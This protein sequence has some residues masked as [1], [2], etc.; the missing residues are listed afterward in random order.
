MKP[1]YKDQIWL[2][3]QYIEKKRSPND[4]ANEIGVATNTIIYWLKKFHIP[5]R[6]Y[7]EANHLKAANHVQ[8]SPHAIEFIEGELLGDG[9]LYSRSQWS[10]AYSHGSKYKE[11]ID[12]LAERLSGF[13]IKQAGS[14]VTQHPL[15]R[16]T[17]YNY[18]S[19]SYEELKPMRDRW[20]PKGKKIVP[21][22]LILTPLMVRQW[23]IGDGCLDTKRGKRSSIRL[24]TCSFSV[25]DVLYLAHSLRE[26]GFNARRRSSHNIIYISPRSVAR[27]LNWIGPCPPE[28]ESIY[29][30]KW[31]NS[32]PQPRKTKTQYQGV[33]WHERVGKWRAQ[34]GIN[35]KYHFLGYFSSELEAALAYDRAAV[36]YRGKDTTVN[37][38]SLSWKHKS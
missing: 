4:I 17:T 6:S 25:Q 16:Y 14:M 26:L 1:F 34:I 7:S 36:Q 27:F 13:G 33:T 38:P 18:I 11:Y 29:G 30:Y 2:R 32:I 9:S 28:I 37:F 8:L 3:K 21:H 22:D 12:W 31:G 15:G 10:A 20:Y 19:L 23:Y 35:Y 24:S 5:R